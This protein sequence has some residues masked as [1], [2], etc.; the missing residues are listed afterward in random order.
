MDKN[1]KDTKPKISK[2]DFALLLFVAIFFDVV[3]S[4]IQL[5]PFVGSVASM[6]FNVIPLTLFYIF[7]SQ[8]GI[9]FSNP[10]KAISFWGAGIIE[11]IPIVNIIPAWTAEVIF[12]YVL[13]RKEEILAKA[14]GVVG[15]VAGTAEMT[16]KV[17]NKFGNKK[18]GDT[19]TKAS[20][21]L[22]EL[23][24][25][26]KTETNQTQTPQNQ[27]VGNEILKTNQQNTGDLENIVPFPTKEEKNTKEISPF[28]NSTKEEPHNKDW[29][30]P[31]N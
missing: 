1:S 9:S 27:I 15:N 29:I 4:A 23:Q 19:F 6:V 25:K 10:K 16:G 21:D 8:L 31:N 20:S 13:Q 28:S 5:I 26:L 11:F 30:F 14:V 24:K 7:Y 17:A 2:K 3:L 12:M 18:M 22:K